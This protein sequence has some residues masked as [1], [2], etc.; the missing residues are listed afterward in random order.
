[1]NIAATAPTVASNVRRAGMKFEKFTAIA[2]PPYFRDYFPAAL[3]SSS[4]LARFSRS[5]ATSGWFGP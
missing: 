1:M 3:I 4:R 5:A 2:C